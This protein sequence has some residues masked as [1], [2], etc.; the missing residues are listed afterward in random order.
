MDGIDDRLAA[1]LERQAVPFVATAPPRAV[2]IA[3]LPAGP[4]DAPVVS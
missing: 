4:L 3:G 2:S 1:W